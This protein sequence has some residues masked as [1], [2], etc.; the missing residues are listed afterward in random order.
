MAGQINLLPK[1]VSKGKELVKA[2]SVV[3]K[4]AILTVVVFVVVAAIG[5][6][7]YYLS[8]SRLTDLKSQ[9]R[10][11]A[12]SVLNLQSTEAGLVLLR[13]RIEKVTQVLGARE[14]ERIL[15]TQQEILESAPEGVLFGSS[16]ISF[17]SSTIEVFSEDSIQLAQLIDTLLA[18]G[19]Y[20]SLIL[21][22][23][24]YNS[25]SGYEAEFSVY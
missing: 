2:I 10:E 23:V 11:L 7:I 15:A 3:N 12:N 22:G 14:S 8:T 13:D 16:E 19:N 25:F 6:G 4:I 17:G 5:G 18:G 9:E 21:S 20:S 1:D 24:N